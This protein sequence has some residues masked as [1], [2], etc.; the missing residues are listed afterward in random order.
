[1]AITLLPSADTDD[2]SFRITIDDTS[3]TV[4]YAPFA[5]TFSSPNL[6]AGWN[7]FFSDS[8]FADTTSSDGQVGEG[9]SFHVTSGDGASLRIRWN[10]T[11]VTLYGFFPTSLDAFPATISYSVSLDGVPT[12]NYASSFTADPNSED[13]ILAAFT[14][15]ANDAH[16]V[17]LALHNPTGMSD[18]AILMR[19][20]RAVITSALPA[21]TTTKQ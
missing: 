6:T 14:G 18:D 12:T 9:T 21:Q 11:A 4:V 1:M 19:F 15:L 10:G 13:N 7:P 17:E 16:I 8:G 2:G 5:D 20:D 3:P